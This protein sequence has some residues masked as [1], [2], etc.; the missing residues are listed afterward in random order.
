[1]AERSWSK[2]ARHFAILL[3]DEDTKIIAEIQSNA[4]D[5]REIIQAFRQDLVRKEEETK[6]TLQIVQHG[7]KQM[8]NN[9]TGT[10]L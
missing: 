10:I 2:L 7:L 6:K 8:L 4:E 9:I 3:S 5:W 1:M